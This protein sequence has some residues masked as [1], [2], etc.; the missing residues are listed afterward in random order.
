MMNNSLPQA[1]LS[2]VSKAS[3][4][5]GRTARRRSRKIIRTGAHAIKKAKELEEGRATSPPQPTASR[6]T[7]N[8]DSKMARSVVARRH[9]RVKASKQ[10]APCGKESVSGDFNEDTNILGNS[11]P[12]K[13]VYNGFNKA[14]RNPASFRGPPLRDESTNKPDPI[15]SGIQESESAP[16]VRLNGGGFRRD[17]TTAQDVGNY[18]MLIDDLSYLCSAIIQCRTKAVDCR[19]LSPAFTYTHS[20]VSVGASCD[21][22]ELISHPSTR[23]KMLSVYSTSM[24]SPCDGTGIETGVVKVGALE[25][26]LESVACAP[27]VRDVSLICRRLIEARS[28]QYPNRESDIQSEL[29]RSSCKTEDVN[30]PTNELDSSAF[31]GQ[32]SEQRKYD[33]IS[34]KALSIISY[35]IGVDCTISNRSSIASQ[36]SKCSVVQVTR[37]SVLSHKPALQGIARLVANDPVVHAYLLNAY[38]THTNNERYLVGAQR[39]HPTTAKLCLP[40]RKLQSHAVKLSRARTHGDPTKIG[41]KCRR[42]RY[43]QSDLRATSRDKIPLEL[44]PS[45]VN[46]IQGVSREE[47]TSLDFTVDKESTAFCKR[48]TNELAE[49]YDEKIAL[50]FSRTRLLQEKAKD[51]SLDSFSEDCIFCNIWMPFMIPRIEPRKHCD[52]IGASHLALLAAECIIT[53]KDKFSTVNDDIADECCAEEGI[54]LGTD[55]HMQSFLSSE[56]PIVH[57]NEMLRLSGSLNHYSRSLSETFVAILLSF[58]VTEGNCNQCSVCAA[59]LLRRASL[60]SE[61]IDNLCCL[62]PNASI[63]LSLQ[64]SFLVP[65]LLR[66]VAEVSFVVTNDPFSHTFES[67]SLA[68]KTLTSLTHENS[69]ACNQLLDPHCWDIPLPASSQGS[70]SSCYITGLDIIFSYLFQSVSKQPKSTPQKMNYDNII[71]CLN[72]LTNIIEMVPNP[73]KSVIESI[74]VDVDGS[75]KINGISWLA[76]WIVSKTSGF[77]DSILEGSFGSKSRVSNV[78]LDELKAGEEDNLVTSGNGFVL[79][80]CLMIDD[81]ESPSHSIRNSVLKELP[82]DNDGNFIGFQFIVRTLKAFCNFYHYSVGDLSVAVIAPV[83]KL[84][85]GLEQMDSVKCN[86]MPPRNMNKSSMNA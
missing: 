50:S 18:R 2:D 53:G 68:L 58:R 72:I 84:I 67:I 60:L 65:S 57:A 52:D 83:V 46:E 9:K 4:P 32:M 1:A 36:S 86:E 19:G 48:K 37:E 21:I 3:P 15:E 66:A 43:P 54:S 51:K 17:A 80:A 31:S 70:K 47:L 5:K 75:E 29:G 22:A 69:V 39:A 62:S 76:Q 25:A 10:L 7:G 73:T 49:K 85:T 16:I 33:A 40:S 81:A 30:S 24:K 11:D 8:E 74:V 38:R 64:E 35:F 26:I 63:M 55:V 44:M 34:S 41:R 28:F 56:N 23:S 14:N 77:K 45:A 82:I 79:L 59:Y 13:K 27:N 61:V 6:R 12:S 20:P 78:D 71:F 42:N